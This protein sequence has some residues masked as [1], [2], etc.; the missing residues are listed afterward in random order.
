V[1]Y[2]SVSDARVIGVDVEVRPQNREAIESHPLAPRI[3]LI[4]GDSV[5]ASTF[6]RVR[7][8]V[9]D[10]TRVL[11]VLDSKHTK[12]HVL[13]E[14]RLY[15]ELVSPGSYLVVADG[16]MRDLAGAPRSST[17]WSWN[18]PAAAVEEFLAENAEF[19]RD[20]PPPLFDESQVRTPVTYFGGGWLRRAR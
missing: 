4:E 8:A 2:A 11:V 16:I 15:G 3:T 18:N 12:E 10:A 13:E 7:E 14:L 17:D 20:E 6:A 1:L 5:A 9:G 19:V